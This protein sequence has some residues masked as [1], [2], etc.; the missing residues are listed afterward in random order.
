M[1]PKAA[2]ALIES[3]SFECILLAH[4]R[5]EL[6]RQVQAELSR[7]PNLTII[8]AGQELGRFLLDKPRAERGRLAQEWLLGRTGG[9]PKDIALL[10][11]I[12]LLFEPSFGLD[13]LMLFR[14]AGR[15]GPLIVLWPGEYKG[16][17]LTYAV[18]EHRHY[19]VWHSP[20]VQVFAI[21]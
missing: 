10:T 21:D 11:E 4:P 3:R 20:D 7:T 17:L 16:G 2:H 14:Q 18:P 13:P 1:I 6:L 12:D 15:R 9:L 8:S 19:R 5:V